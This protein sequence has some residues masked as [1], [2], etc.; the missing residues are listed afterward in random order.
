MN[1]YNPLSVFISFVENYCDIA[2]IIWYIV[3]PASIVFLYNAKTKG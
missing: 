3:L 2:I 1:M